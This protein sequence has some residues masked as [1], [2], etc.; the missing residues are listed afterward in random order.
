MLVY[1]CD[2]VA[3]PHSARAESAQTEK[4]SAEKCLLLRRKLAKLVA[5]II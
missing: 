5:Y 2:A 3:R 1:E 4:R